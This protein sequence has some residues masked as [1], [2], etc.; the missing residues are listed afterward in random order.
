[1]TEFIPCNVVLY[2]MSDPPAPSAGAGVVEHRQCLVSIL[3]EFKTACSY[4]AAGAWVCPERAAALSGPPTNRRKWIPFKMALTLRSKTAQDRDSPQVRTP[5]HIGE[6][7]I[8]D[9]EGRALVVAMARPNVGQFLTYGPS[10]MFRGF[11]SGEPLLKT[12]IYD[13]IA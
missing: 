5:Q 7:A 2:F 13:K 3:T 10:T 4:A 8:C 9:R 12:T 6:S 1:M 11:R